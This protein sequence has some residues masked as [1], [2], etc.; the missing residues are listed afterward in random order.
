MAFSKHD[1]D[2][3]IIRQRKILTIPEDEIVRVEQ[4]HKDEVDINNIIR[5]HGLDLIAKTA[6]MQ[7]FQ[8]DDNPNNDFQEIMNAVLKASDSFE[9]LPSQIRKQFDNN[10]A[11]FMDFIY[12]PE[13]ADKMVE[14]GLANPPPPPTEP[15]QVTVTNQE[16]PPPSGE[17]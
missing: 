16:T 3:V 2:G 6:Q 13:N 9:S 5:R 14:M 1:S 17:A 4:H 11:Q 10:P 8:Y 15:I 12:N 7:Q